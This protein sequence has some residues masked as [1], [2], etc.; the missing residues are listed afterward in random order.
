[1]NKYAVELR[2]VYGKRVWHVLDV[3]TMYTVCRCD[4]HEN[5]ATVRDALT[6]AQSAQ[7]SK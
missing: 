1:M 3:S 6:L 5:A 7:V 2:T 4:S